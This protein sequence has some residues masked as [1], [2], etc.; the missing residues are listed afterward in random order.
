MD[1]RYGGERDKNTMKNPMIVVIDEKSG[2]MANYAPGE[3]GVVEWLIK[4]RWRTR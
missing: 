2:S 3:K 1:Y 4:R